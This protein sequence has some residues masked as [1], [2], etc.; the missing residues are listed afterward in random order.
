MS[1]KKK[2]MAF[3]LNKDSD[4]DCSMSKI[5]NL[6]N[7]SQSTVSSAIKEIG[8]KKQIMDL[9]DEIKETRK[10]LIEQNF[11]NQNRLLSPIRLIESDD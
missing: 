10:Q 11:Q 8:Y 9:E 7:V 1:D 3:V 5:G 6:F 2:L 4:F